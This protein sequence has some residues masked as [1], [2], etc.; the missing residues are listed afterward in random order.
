[1]FH[2][3]DG[4]FLDCKLLFGIVVV[5]EYGTVV[6]VALYAVRVRIFRTVAGVTLVGLL[7]EIF[8]IIIGFIFIPRIGDDLNSKNYFTYI[9]GILIIFGLRNIIDEF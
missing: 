5:N 7:R 6:R 9:H 2:Q 4:E 3:I 8:L 1:M